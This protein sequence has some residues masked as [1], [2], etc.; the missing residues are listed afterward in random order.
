MLCHVVDYVAIVVVVAAV[1]VSCCELFV[2]SCKVLLA[3]GCWPLLACCLI[4]PD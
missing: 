3:E 4:M 2:A 1:V